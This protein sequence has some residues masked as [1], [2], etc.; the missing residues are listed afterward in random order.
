MGEVN[1]FLPVYTSREFDR[2]WFCVWEIF[3]LLSWGASGGDIWIL[4]SQSLF[5]L[6]RHHNLEVSLWVDHRLCLFEIILSLNNKNLGGKKA[7]TWISL[8]DTC[9]LWGLRVGQCTTSLKIILTGSDA[10][11]RDQSENFA[12]EHPARLKIRFGSS[13]WLSIPS[14]LAASP[15][16]RT[17]PGFPNRVCD[18]QGP[19]LL[20][21]SETPAKRLPCSLLVR[22]DVLSS[23][24]V[25]LQAESPATSSSLCHWQIL[26]SPQRSDRKMQPASTDWTDWLS[27]GGNQRVIA[28]GHTKSG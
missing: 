6:I 16:P 28:A 1:G 20:P 12:W 5:V 23:L 8:V 11:E 24:S 4:D 14:H 26:I 21:T 25:H 3:V 17:L 27:Q 7:K 19:S 10:E 15:V 9:E 13:L 2:R 18:P 22:P